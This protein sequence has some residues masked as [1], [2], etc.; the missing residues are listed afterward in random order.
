ML[1]GSHNSSKK[2]KKQFPHNSF[3]E[4]KVVWKIPMFLIIILTS[5]SSEYT[6]L[7]PCTAFPRGQSFFV[8]VPDKEG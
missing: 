7:D 5:G 2:E 6:A 1:P 4:S 8:L 3:V